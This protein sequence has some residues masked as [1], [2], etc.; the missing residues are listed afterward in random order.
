MTVTPPE[1]VDANTPARL[2]QVRELMRP[3][4]AWHR[5]RHRTDLRL[6]DDYFDA[7]AFDAVL[8]GLPREVRPAGRPAPPG[9]A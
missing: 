5:E 1:V 7:A 2:D 9:A 6:I 3:F 4:V 8:T